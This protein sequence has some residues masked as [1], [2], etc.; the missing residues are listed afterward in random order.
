MR[1]SLAVDG[2]A[3]NFETS[4]KFF[5]VDQG[6]EVCTLSGTPGENIYIILSAL[7]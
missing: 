7:Y 2:E 6:S 3:D 5:T 1:G 4:V